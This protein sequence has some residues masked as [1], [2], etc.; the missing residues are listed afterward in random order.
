[1]IINNLAIIPA[2]SGSKGV[3]NK[4]IMDINENPFLKYILKTAEN[5]SNIDGIFFSTDSHEYLNIFNKLKISKNLTYNYLRNENI[6]KGTSTVTEY[7]IDC[8][9]FL[10]T[11][12]ITVKNII[13]LQVTN[14]LITSYEIEKAINI[15]DNS[16]YNYLISVSQPIQH[17]GCMLN[18]NKETNEFNH[19]IDFKGGNRQDYK[20]NIY[21][22]NGNLYIGKVNEILK[23]TDNKALF[24]K[25][26]ETYFFYQDTNSGFQVD[27][28]NDIVIM[29]TMLKSP[30][31]IFLKNGWIVEK[32]IFSE[33]ELIFLQKE[34]YKY[35][36][37][38]NKTFQIYDIQYTED[39]KINSVHCLHKYDNR[40]VDFFKNHMKL[41]K[42]VNT[43]LGEKVEILAI[44]AFLKPEGSGLDVPLH[45]DNE[46]FCV[47]DEKAFTA[48]IALDNISEINGG[49]KLWTKSNN[50]GLLKH[51]KSYKKG[52]SMTLEKSAIDIIGK[53]NFIINKLNPGDV[54]FHH[55]LTVHGSNKNKSDHSRNV[56]TV[57]YKCINSNINR[58]KKGKYRKSVIEN[59][60]NN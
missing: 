4:N 32:N 45:Q 56:I 40:F 41:N 60:T 37:T 57:Q 25:N 31:R 19:I 38:H 5:V 42:I 8:L 43:L 39:S 1:M 21:F 27:N 30:S 36:K 58:E 14:P 12:E 59:N 9:T 46:L 50:L 29:E 15:F 52:T 34:I 7:I 49:L 35:T 2:R 47:E 11:R 10:K 44:E 6:S 24:L 17:I 18:I 48:W 55:C 26:N 54:Q 16:K 51:E 28:Y 20:D 3:K 22:I 13:I 33:F 53:N 23:N